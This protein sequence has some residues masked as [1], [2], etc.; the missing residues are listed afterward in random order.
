M[1]YGRMSHLLSKAIWLGADQPLSK[2]IAKKAN[3]RS[4]YEATRRCRKGLVISACPNRGGHFV[5]PGKKEK[6]CNALGG[7]KS[8]KEGLWIKRGSIKLFLRELKNF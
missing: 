5:K 4:F 2:S 8:E 3:F 6:A 1:L 7:S